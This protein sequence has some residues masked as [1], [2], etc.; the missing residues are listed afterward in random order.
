MFLGATRKRWTIRT[1]E[2]EAGTGVD[3][4]EA[5]PGR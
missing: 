2:K 5:I 1:G 3:Q 4:R